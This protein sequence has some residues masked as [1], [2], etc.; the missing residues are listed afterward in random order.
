MDRLSRSQSPETNSQHLLRRHPQSPPPPSNNDGNAR[1]N[2]SDN[3]LTGRPETRKGFYQFVKTKFTGRTR[4][5]AE[6]SASNLQLVVPLR[7]DRL[8]DANRSSQ[9]RE[10]SRNHS[11]DDDDDAHRSSLLMGQ[12]P[13]AAQ[14]LREVCSRVNPREIRR[15]AGIWAERRL[16]RKLE[17]QARLTERRMQLEVDAIESIPY[18]L[19]LDDGD[20]CCVICLESFDTNMVRLYCSHW[21]C[22][23][24]LASKLKTI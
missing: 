14:D 8:E 19:G 15:Y 3:P 13:S 10:G 11:D 20:R 4:D 7:S 23:T 2:D 22:L 1:P 16:S 21:Y 9:N 5:V 24:D 12:K 18:C 6:S 17:R